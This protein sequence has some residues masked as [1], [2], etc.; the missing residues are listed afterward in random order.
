MMSLC[1]ESGLCGNFAVVE[2]TG[3]VFPCDE[4]TDSKYL[5]GNVTKTPLKVILNSSE[6]R[7]FLNKVEA[8]NG[9]CAKDCEAYIACRGGCT[10]CHEFYKGS[11][12]CEHLKNVTSE[13]KSYVLQS[14]QDNVA[15]SRDSE[16]VDPK[17]LDDLE[18]T[19]NCFCAGT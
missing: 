16:L 7:K 15:G 19:G 6:R 3:E 1:S 12:Y 11:S 5:W 18:D 10:F 4:L 8:R 13:V 17:L 9:E 14:L 2:I